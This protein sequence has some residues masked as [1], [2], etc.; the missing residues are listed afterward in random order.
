MTFAEA[1]RDPAVYGA[2]GPVEVRE[3][4]ISWVFLAGDRAYKLK[5][6]VTLAFVDY[7]TP[8]RRRAMCEEEVRLNRRLAPDVYL[9]VRSVV[10]RGGAYALGPPGAHGAVDHV[11]EM[12]RFD[13]SQT[14]AARLAAG[15]VSEGDV[16]SVAR[17]IA[18]FHR[19]AERV[20]FA[21]GADRLH[22]ALSDSLEALAG[23]EGIDALR[24]FAG[25]YERGH[26]RLLAERGALAVD[27]HADLRA[28]HVVLGDPVQ[29]VDCVEFDRDLRVRDP[30]SDLAFLAMD[31]EAQGHPAFARRLVGAYRAAGG[32]AG[33]D[34]LMAFYAAERALVRAK[35]DAI[36]ADQLGGDA[37]LAARARDRI[38]L[39]RRLSWRARGPL[40]LIVCGLSGSGK[41][42]LAGALAE[43]LDARVLASD[44]V[45]K[46]LAGVPATEHAPPERYLREFSIR[47]Y[48]ELAGRA[49][50]ALRER[51]TPVVIDAT[52]RNP[53]D[54]R[55]L[56]EG[57]GADPLFVECVAPD[58]VL[59]DRVRARSA[60]G[61]SMSDADE[62]VLAAQRFAPIDE[63]SPDRVRALATDRPVE[64][65]V[66]DVEAWLD[67]RLASG[68]PATDPAAFG[69]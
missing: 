62:A 38:A 12:R 26:S 50:D 56:L 13:E 34:H 17:A 14:L 25:A 51:A 46:E 31:I 64:C 52:S 58:A 18:A 44:R 37:R 23:R 59:L 6:P 11:V 45:R 54:R 47:V 5:K 65:I 67:E 49:R 16:D 9:G 35:V 4:H 42:H 28:E 24:R 60:A 30:A 29:I 1:L 61:H 32:N 68:K 10:P 53:E 41:S 3:T 21:D 8:E 15:S 7:G 27:G 2:E 66:D 57:L 22:A 36:R 55:A 19:G 39:A 69:G 63:V 48:A 20:P 40:A 33:P 43:S